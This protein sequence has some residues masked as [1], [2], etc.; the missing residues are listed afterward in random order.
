M[1]QRYRVMRKLATGG[2]AEV[3]LGVVSGAEGFEKPVALKRMLAHLTSD[4]RMVR[5]FL[6]EAQLARHLHHQNIVTVFDVG[7]DGQG[8]VFLVMEAVN[9]WDLKL[10]RSVAQKA[11][12]TFPPHLAAWIVAQ[13]NAG[14]MHAYA[15]RVNGKAVLSAHRDISDSNVL[16]SSEGEVKVA[17]FG[18]ARVELMNPLTE[19]GSF[20]GRISYAA[21]EVLSGLPATAASDQFALGILFHELLTGKH[22][23][24]EAENLT[25]Y[26]QRITS[27]Q[28]VLTHVPQVLRPL[29]ERMLQRD[30]AARYAPADLSRALSTYLASCG[31]PADPQELSS[32]IETLSPPPPIVEQSPP[33]DMTPVP[34]NYWFEL[35]APS[36]L[37]EKDEWDPVGALDQSG[38]FERI[39]MPVP[40][41][42]PPPARPPARVMEAPP[43]PVVPAAEA[44]AP[45]AFASH[46]GPLELAREVR[47]EDAP[48]PAPGHLYGD[49]V[50]ARWSWRPLVALLAVALL[51][52]GAWLA[53]PHVRPRL[54]AVVPA[55]EKP[56]LTFTSQPSGATIIVSGTE[57]GTTPYVTENVWPDADIP[58]EL[59]LRGHQVW[60]GEFRGGMMQTVDAR[61]QRKRGG[62]GR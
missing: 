9:G 10:L 50:P 14:L 62:G 48:E 34:R 22:P 55:G 45:G 3:F 18:I 51:A 53:W 49:P 20:K 23:W 57:L 19:P 46:E 31:A 24:E 13:V 37:P 41:A 16:V 35:E 26:I 38:R 25:A 7:R 33:E 30:P 1:E 61:L 12:A 4:E 60:K 43:E 27:E 47:G 5:M 40:P 15:R 39:Q 44:P 42:A 58:V 54:A 6:A 52:G 8:N 32:F 2:M 21:P 11:G 28:P 17:D 36:P 59:R 56:I 29:L